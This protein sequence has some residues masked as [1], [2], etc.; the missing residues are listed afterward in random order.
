MKLLKVG[1]SVI[2]EKNGYKSIDEKTVNR[3]TKEIAKSPKK[4][5]LVHGAGSYGHPIVKEENLIKPKK[6]TERD[7]SRKALISM[8]KVRRSVKELNTFF[9]KS[10]N[11]HGAPTLTIHPSSCVI[12]KKGQI[13]KFELELIYSAIKKEMIPILHGDMVLDTEFGGSVLS[14]DKIISYIARNSKLEIDRIGMA[15]KTP[16]LNSNGEKIDKFKQKHKKHLKTSESTDVTGG[17]KNKVKELLDTNI[18][19]YIFDATKPESIT[20]FL[21]GQKIGTEIK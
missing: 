21:E 10:L 13:K 3:V 2:T 9:V 14:G 8:E 4:L 17:M 19:S 5:I 6:I 7:R 16:V 18:P 15:T 11:E 1:G 12:S 20:K